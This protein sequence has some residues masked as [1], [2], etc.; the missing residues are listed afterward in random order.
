MPNLKVTAL[1]ALVVGFVVAA[2][3]A[4]ADGISFSLLNPSQSI[5]P[6]QTVSFDATVTATSGNTK[7]IFLNGDT[8][9]ITDKGSVFVLND[10]D[11][12]N[13]FPLLLTPTGSGDTYT[14]AIFTITN[15]GSVTEA[16]SGTFSLLGGVNAAAMRNLGTVNFGS[17][18]A[19]STVPEP[20]SLLLLGTGTVGLVSAG[21]RRF[22]QIL[23]HHAAK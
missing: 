21:R 23:R 5:A 6:G 7:N 17:P 4:F 19:V 10:T 13:N 8:S 15:N 22:Y 16:Y 20:S 3:S 9:D 18:A 11:F 12:F 1:L 2:P 14:G